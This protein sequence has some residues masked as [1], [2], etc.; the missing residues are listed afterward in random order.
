MS[1]E[2]TMSIITT[3]L[4]EIHL[5]LIRLIETMDCLSDSRTLE[6][7]GG[8]AAVSVLPTLST[9][10]NLYLEKLETTMLFLGRRD[11]A[12]KEVSQA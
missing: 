10:A 1:P 9:V 2:E 3:Q 4:D 8:T 11:L 5:G 6:S 12:A 7:E